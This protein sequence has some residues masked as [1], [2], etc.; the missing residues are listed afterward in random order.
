MA[1]L[2][3]GLANIMAG[4]GQIV[5]CGAYGN[6]DWTT[7]SGTFQVVRQC[8]LE[9]PANGYVFV[10]ADGGMARQDGEYEAHFEI[11]IDSVTGDPSVDRW[12]NVYNDAGD[13]TDKSLALS[14]LAPVTAGAHTFYLLGRRYGGAGTVLVYDPTLSVIFVPATAANVQVCGA[15]GNL[16]WTTTSSTFQEVRQCSLNVPSEGLAFITTDT[17]LARQD[18]EY[19]AQFKIGVDSTAGDANSD[20][21]VNVYNDAGDGSD[22]TVRISA[23]LP[24]AAGNHTFYSL[25]KRYVGAGTVHLYDPT[26]TVIFLPTPNVTLKGCGASGYLDWTTTLSSFQVIRQCTIASTGAG[27][28][29]LSADGSVACQDGEY[30]AQ[31]QIAIDNTAGNANTDR[32]MNIYNDAGDGSDKGLALSVLRPITQGTHTFYL[33]GRRYSGTGTVLVYDPTLSVIASAPR[34]LLPLITRQ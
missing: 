3:A 21:W 10:S 9:V 25:A 22:E 23:L 16:D 27:W 15:S 30:E 7:T 29:F 24:L 20:R 34:V 32:W 19:E 8:A 11:G 33:L 14:V 4:S 1:G 5:T 31:F 2:P 6:L 13:G 18:G 17:S 28:A 26:L 12:V